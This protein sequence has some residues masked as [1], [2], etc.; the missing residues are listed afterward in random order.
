MAKTPKQRKAAAIKFFSRPDNVGS[1]IMDLLEEGWNACDD[2]R[3]DVQGENPTEARH[4]RTLTREEFADA[5]RRGLIAFLRTPEGAKE[6]ARAMRAS[7]DELTEDRE[8]DDM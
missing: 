3:C 2:G 8:E 1:W 5:H 7:Y 6:F 4:A